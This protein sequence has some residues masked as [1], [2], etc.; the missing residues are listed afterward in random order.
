MTDEA[1]PPGPP[2]Q[3]VPHSWTQAWLIAV[4][5]P[6]V[7][8][9]TA[10]AE[11]PSAT[12]G[13][14]FAWIFVSGLIASAVSS[15]LRLAFISSTLSG[16]EQTSDSTLGIGVVA[17]LTF[18]CLVPFSAAFAGV[19]LM[20]SAG[21]QQF[22]AGALGGEGSFTR[23]YYVMAAY[24]A[25][26]SV[27]AALLAIIPF[28]GACVGALLGFYTIALNALA[29]KAVNR[30]GWGNAIL[31]MIV[32]LIFVVLIGVIIFFAFLYPAISTLISQPA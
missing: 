16:L 8:S 7:Q 20:V 9:Y 6:N 12:L 5:Q 29:I 13:K 28:L 25:P 30:F 14:A 18:A 11:D 15:L 2:T 10:L 21:I 27:A 32:P 31:S 26:I 4:T 3:A 17:L 24:T 23:L 22:V 19:V 1:L